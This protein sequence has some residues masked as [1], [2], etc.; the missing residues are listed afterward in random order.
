MATV[1]TVLRSGAEF[2]PEHVQ[3]MQR[4][5][6]KYSPPDTK[7]LCISDVPVAGVEVIPMKYHWP[8]WWCKLELFRPDLDLG[9]F[10]FTDLDNIVVGRLD[11]ILKTD[12]FML[13]W[14]G[15][16]ALMCLPQK[17]RHEV[18]RP[19]IADPEKHMKTFAREN[20][21]VVNGIGNYGDA[22][23]ISSQALRNGTRYW[24][25]AY[26]DQVVNI[27]YFKAPW[28]FRVRVSEQLMGETRIIMAG[29]PNR[30]WRMHDGKMR[31]AYWCQEPT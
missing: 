19:F 28:P 21:P 4:Q 5:V 12:D 14:G 27:A 3:A 15:W 13:Q 17:M 16:T 25:I 10:I 18:W 30:P 7:Y 22:G 24:E 26:P 31:A 29:Q 11:D 6:R 23:F 9:D 20:R 8:N 1:V 2:G